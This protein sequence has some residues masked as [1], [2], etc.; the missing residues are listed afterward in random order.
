MFFLA[1]SSVDICTDVLLFAPQRPPVGSHKYSHASYF[2]PAKSR[3]NQRS[4]SRD[5]AETLAKQRVGRGSD[6]RVC[7]G[8]PTD[9]PRLVP[10][11]MLH[12]AR[13]LPARPGSPRPGR[14]R[15]GV[16]A[17]T[18][19]GPT[20]AGGG[21]RCSDGGGV[22]GSGPWQRRLRRRRQRWRRQRRWQRR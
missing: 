10:P 17:S 14:N 19:R 2:L 8:Q 5:F 13:P 1:C 4:Y 21:G 18:S 7:R 6:Q 20:G 9:G 22:G 16:T 11:C 12:K 15:C 3:K